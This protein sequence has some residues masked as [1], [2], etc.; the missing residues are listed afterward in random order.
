MSAK[1][2]VD[3]LLGS[4]APVEPPAGTQPPLDRAF[5]N[6][7]EEAKKK[8]APAWR[9]WGRWVE[10][11]LVGLFVLIFVVWAIRTLVAG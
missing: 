7:A 6:H 11:T 5:K 8:A 4:L 1:D 3:D 9:A 10:P 2:P